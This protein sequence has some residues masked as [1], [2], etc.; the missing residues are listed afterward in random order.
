[1]ASDRLSELPDDLLIRILSFVPVKGGRKHHPPLSPVAQPAVA[2]DWHLQ[3]RLDVGAILQPR[4]QL[5]GDVARRGRRP[6]SAPPRPPPP[7]PQ[8]A[9]RHGDSQQG[10]RQLL[11][12]FLGIPQ[13]VRFP[14][15]VRA[16]VPERRG[17]P[18]RVPD[19]RPRR[20]RAVV[21]VL[22]AAVHVRHARPRVQSPSAPPAMRGFPGSSPH[23][24][25]PERGDSSMSSE[26]DRLPV[27]DDAAAPAV[28]RAARRA[29]ET[30]HRR[31]GARRRMSR[32][33]HLPGSGIR[34]RHDHR[35]TRPSPLPGGHRLR[36]G[37]LP[38]VL[39]QLRARCAGVDLLPLR[40]D[41]ILRAIH[42]AETT[43]AVLGKG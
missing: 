17:A 15:Q 34:R 2:G 42:L 6:G 21:V 9:L 13:P 32:V 10:R 12:G 11:F 24:M 39:P 27:P 18:P 4:P 23:G 43:C 30:D 37:Q 31:A 1:M 26:S 41:L 8:E 3:R 25:Q 38:H 29:P 36:H 7:P 22:A 35:Q 40:P 5:P 28:H 14:R 33:S 20:S 19:R 16:D